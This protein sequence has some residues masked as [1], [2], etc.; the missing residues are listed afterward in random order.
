MLSSRYLHL[1]E[2]LGLGPM[3]LLRGA[4]VLPA[5]P[6]FLMSETMVCQSEWPKGV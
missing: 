6:N 3:W 5:E 4:H 2:A 1:H